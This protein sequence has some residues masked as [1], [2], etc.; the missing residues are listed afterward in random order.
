[1]FL[2]R[3]IR[4]KKTRREVMFFGQE[5]NLEEIL[6]IERLQENG[7]C[8]R[9]IQGKRQTWRV[10]N[11]GNTYYVKIFQNNLRRRIVSALRLSKSQKELQAYLNLGTKNILIPELIAYAQ[12]G[13]ILTRNE[14]LITKEVK[15]SQSLRDFFLKDFP[16]LSRHEQKKIIYDFAD[17]IRIVHDEGVVPL[18]PNLGNF[19]IK[20]ESNNNHFYLLDLAEI[21]LKSS[22]R[23]EDRWKN[24]S[25]VNLNFLNVSKILRYYFFKRYCNGLIN[26]KDDI[27]KTIQKIEFLSFKAAR[28]VWRKKAERCL[29]NNRLFIEERFDNL[30]AHLKRSR[31]DA[32]GIQE[33]LKSPDSFLEGD[34]GIILKNGRTTKGAHIKMDD[35][36]LFLKRY[37]NKGF[38]HTFKNIFRSSRAKRVWLRGYGFELRG[39]P[40]ASPVAYMEER[41]FRILKRSYVVSE[42]ITDAVTLSSIFRHASSDISPN[43][44]M[45][46]MQMAGSEIGKMHKLGCIHGDMKWSNILIKEIDE[47]SNCFFVDLDGSRIKRRLSLSEIIDE[48]S[49]FYVEMLK[50][51][52]NL[53]DQEAFLKAYCSHNHPRISYKELLKR[54]KEKA[55]PK[56]ER[57]NLS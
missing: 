42:F 31:R 13:S 8:V 22:L 2:S 18:D 43:Q 14:Y 44:T 12:E 3:S 25:L 39:I 24:L 38:F 20:K 19:L 50:Y 34:K 41:R 46:I 40:I 15:D 56:F 35:R 33:L 5:P 23:L 6:S 7:I 52:I 48:L 27:R 10:F 16:L 1:M 57:L 54:I 45:A 9:N 17:F 11:S 51:K 53:E 32:K 47:K 30:M 4:L 55:I 29:K 28:S 49:R 26:T 21:K 36:Q 37:N